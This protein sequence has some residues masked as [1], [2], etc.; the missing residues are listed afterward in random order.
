MRVIDKIGCENFICKNEVPCTPKFDIP[1][2]DGFVYF[3]IHNIFLC[4]AGSCLVLLCSSSERRSGNSALTAAKG[5]WRRLRAIVSVSTVLKKRQSSHI[6][7]GKSGG[8]I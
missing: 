3:D 6:S 5:S 4:L 8:V 1:S 2:D 7:G